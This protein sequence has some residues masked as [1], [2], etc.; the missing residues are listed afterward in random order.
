MSSLTVRYS[1]PVGLGHDAHTGYLNCLLQVLTHTPSLG[2]L[3]SP[4]TPIYAPLFRFFKRYKAAVQC[5]LEQI[6]PRLGSLAEYGNKNAFKVFQ[7]LCDGCREISRPFCLVFES[8][9]GCTNCYISQKR[10][11]AH[12]L[13][14]EV[15]KGTGSDVRAITNL[16]DALQQLFRKEP[17]C[18]GE[19]VRSNQIQLETVG[20]AVGIRLKR[21]VWDE[22]E[23]HVWRHDVSLPEELDL[24]DQTGDHKYALYAIVLQEGADTHYIACVKWEGT[25]WYIEDAN[26]EERPFADIPT[27]QASLAFYQRMQSAATG[28]ASLAFY[29]RMRSDLEKEQEEQFRTGVREKWVELNQKIREGAE[30]IWVDLPEMEPKKKQ[31]LAICE[32]GLWFVQERYVA[33]KKEGGRELHGWM[34]ANMW[35]NEPHLA[36]V[37]FGLPWVY[38]EDEREWKLEMNKATARVFADIWR[39]G[40]G[41]HKRMRRQDNSV[42]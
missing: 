18:T 23:V 39:D 11:S 22:A 25:W 41:S 16:Q 10:E 17:C 20:E 31:Q 36:Q 15:T 38:K 6:E 34:E 14:V 4:P 19:R 2:T 37:V 30:L 33:G 29:Q 8:T 28:Q 35:D 1:A 21:E 27:G 13:T 12:M 32:Q 26:V 24:S 7:L 3:L 9:S 42:G 40:G 5:R